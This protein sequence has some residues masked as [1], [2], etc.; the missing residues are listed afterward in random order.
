MVRAPASW[1]A[2]IRR[3]RA[4][5]SRRDPEGLNLLFAALRWRYDTARNQAVEALAALGPW[6]V[7][8]LLRTLE[9]ATT[10]VERRSAADALGLMGNRR[11]I[12]RLLQRLEDPNMSV[13]R[14][15]TRALLRVRARSSIPPIIRLLRDPSGGVRVLVAGVLGRFG[16]RSAVPALVRALQDSKWYV[17]QVTAEALGELRDFRARMPLVQALRDSR[18]AV[19]RAARA[20]LIA[21]GPRSDRSR[22]VRTGRKEP[23][24]KDTDEG[25][26]RKTKI[27]GTPVPPPMAK[28]KRAAKKKAY[29]AGRKEKKARK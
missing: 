7:P 27:H 11:A 8:R 29:Y 12:P 16:D 4:L 15:A 14:S 6:P 10:A 19:V 23:A 1:R 9:T 17:R 20:A 2:T 21:I 26:D 5:V 28:R 13:R 24:S 25:P 3:A 22:T 18:P